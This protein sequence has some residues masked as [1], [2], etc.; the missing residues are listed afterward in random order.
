MN[1]KRDHLL[2]EKTIANKGFLKQNK[3]EIGYYVHRR[4]LNTDI[5]FDILK[6]A[7]VVSRDN[8]SLWHRRSQI[9]QDT[10]FT[11]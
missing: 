1:P 6:A 4:D 8:R 3:K 11:N 7:S 2:L 10:T 5:H 9:V